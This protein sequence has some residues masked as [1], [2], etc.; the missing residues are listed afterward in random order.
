MLNKPIFELA[1]RQG[2]FYE[3]NGGGLVEFQ[4]ANRVK[5]YKTGVGTLCSSERS[6]FW[7]VLTIRYFRM[8]KRQFRRH[9]LFRTRVSPRLTVKNRPLLAGIAFPVRVTVPISVR[10]AR[11]RQGFRF[12][13]RFFF[14]RFVRNTT[15][16]L[17]L[18]PNRLF[19]VVFYWALD[20]GTVPH[21]R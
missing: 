1:V 14:P 20:L 19:P 3:S 6:V 7:T 8:L 9:T 10:I 15:T 12:S 5:I 16:T 2:H 21:P 4:P 18:P 17:A 11:R 13:H